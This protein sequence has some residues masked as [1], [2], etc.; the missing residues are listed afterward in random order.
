[1]PAIYNI[2]S[3][4]STGEPYII[5]TPQEFQVQKI[6]RKGLGSTTEEGIYTKNQRKEMEEISQRGSA[7]RHWVSRPAEEPLKVRSW[8]KY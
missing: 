7:T 6:L 4:G 2:G 3:R 5:Q 1:M 8:D